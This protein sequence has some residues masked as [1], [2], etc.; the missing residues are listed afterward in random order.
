MEDQTVWFAMF[1]AAVFKLLALGAL[2]SSIAAPAAAPPVA[3]SPVSQSTVGAPS[4]VAVFVGYADS[5]RADPTNFP[6][7]WFGSP[8]TVY[9]GCAPT[10]ACV[11]DAGSVR[12]VNN[13]S[14]AMTINSV[15]V[16]VDS[17]SFTGWPSAVLSP[18][19]DLI[20]TQLASGAVGGCTPT[21]TDM[22]TS[23]LGPGGSNYTGNCTPNGLQPVVD[24]TMNGTTVS[25]VDSGQVLNTGGV[26]AGICSGNESIQ[27]TV[28]GHAPC[29]GSLL[30]L[31]PPGQTHPVLSSA[32][33]T[34]TF[35]NSC[36]QPLSNTAVSFA[37]AAGPNAGLTGSG[38]TNA[39]GQASFTYSSGKLG[40]DTW[41]ASV[42]NLAGNI[43]S[44]T[45]NVTWTLDFAGNGGAFVIGD[46]ENHSGAHVLYWGAQWWKQELMSGGA[47]PAAFKGLELSNPAPTCG[48]TWTTRP[49]NSPHPPATVPSVMGVIVSS[50]ITQKG[51]TISGDVVHIVIVR[52]DPG[53]GPN[54]GHAGTGV[55]VGQIC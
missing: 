44:N 23:D 22:D 16:H 34:A 46:L 45:A 55:I 21:P 7:P 31:T 43:P 40:T 54:P 47:A 32:T 50:H 1:K 10:A 48:S 17:C 19:A 28:I 9:E 33:V 6:T 2:A 30:S 12:I 42:S 24:V 8:G 20:I 5:L 36:G 14:A 25:Y 52:T 51:S 27:W 11:Y 4:G 53:Y 29:R 35:T 37:A 38:V 3:V 49:G 41:R 18:G 26:D 15:A 13:S 39:S